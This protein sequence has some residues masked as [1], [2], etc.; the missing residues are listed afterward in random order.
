MY[1]KDCKHY[2][3]LKTDHGNVFNY[4]NRVDAIDLHE[5]T[6]TLEKSCAIRVGVADDYN[7][8]TFLEVS[9]DF[10]C[11]NFTKKESIG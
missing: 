4:C 11:V 6:Q 2:R 8:S 1:C 7:L 5:S 10:G 9:K 3:K